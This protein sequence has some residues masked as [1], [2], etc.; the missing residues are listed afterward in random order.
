MRMIKKETLEMEDGDTI[1]FYIKILDIIL[2]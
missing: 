1:D 2:D